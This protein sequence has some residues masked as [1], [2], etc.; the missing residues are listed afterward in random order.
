[1]SCFQPKRTALPDITTSA[2]GMS[3][4]GQ[5]AQLPYYDEFARHLHPKL[6]VLVFVEN[7]LYENA[8][9]G[10]YPFVTAKWAGSRRPGCWRR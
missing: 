3:D 8:R 2:F 9:Q 4:T 7:D 10:M 6:V 1:M 5:I